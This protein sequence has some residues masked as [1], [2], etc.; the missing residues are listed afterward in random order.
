MAIK[1][2]LPPR[3]TPKPPKYRSSRQLPA[4]PWCGVCRDIIKLHLPSDCMPDPF[5]SCDTACEPFLVH[6]HFHVQ[7]LICEGEAKVF[8]NIQLLESTFYRG[9]RDSGTSARSTPEPV[10]MPSS[11]TD[12]IKTQRAHRSAPAEKHKDAWK[13]AGNSRW[14]VSPVLQ[15]VWH[16]LCSLMLGSRT[17]CHMS[18]VGHFPDSSLDAEK[19]PCS[20]RWCSAIPVITFPGVSQSLFSHSSADLDRVLSIFQPAW[21]HDPLR[22]GEHAISYTVQ[23]SPTADNMT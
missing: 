3:K 14:K 6:T 5:H 8:V 23:P 1:Q 22:T 7:P 21:L 17:I 10:T 16:W 2:A 13:W 12:T 11:S 18:L 20:G 4:I 9:S 15:T 19:M